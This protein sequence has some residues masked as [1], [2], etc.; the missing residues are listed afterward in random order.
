APG[1]ARQQK[2]SHR[3]TPGGE[4]QGKK[5]GWGTLKGRWV[6][7]DVRDQIVDY[8]RYW[9]Q[10]AETPAKTLLA[11]L[12]LPTSKFHNWKTRY[13]KANEHNGQV[14]RDHWLEDWEQA[15]IV[16]YHDAHPL[17]GYRRLTFMMLDDDI[18]AVS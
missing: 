15:A 18:V 9:S 13:G 2:R 3:R 12:D 5:T 16:E 4:R 10:R 17:E 6:P 7:H 8:V 11:W 14:P 1:Q